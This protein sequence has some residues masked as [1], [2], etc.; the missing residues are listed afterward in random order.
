MPVVS[1]IPPPP[2]LGPRCR[3][4]QRLVPPVSSRRRLIPQHREP[5]TGA[6]SAH[7]LAWARWPLQAK[8]FSTRTRFSRLRLAVVSGRVV[9][10]LHVRL[11]IFTLCLPDLVDFLAVLSA[12]GL[13]GLKDAGVLMVLLPAALPDLQIAPV[14]IGLY[15]AVMW[16]LISSIFVVGSA[17]SQQASVLPRRRHL[18]KRMLHPRSTHF[19]THPPPLPGREGL[20]R[21]LLSLVASA[22][23]AV[24][25]RQVGAEAVMGPSA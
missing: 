25:Q 5:A 17:E 6:A 18:P 12:K 22:V 1:L 2:T 24:L 16:L 7:Q 8:Q 20:C 9:L 19:A 15:T 11:A 13:T 10:H 4:C 21:L 14:V 3:R 23:R